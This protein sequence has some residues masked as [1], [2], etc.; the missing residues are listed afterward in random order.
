MTEPMTPTVPPIQPPYVEQSIS[1]QPPKQKR[2]KPR[3]S[4]DDIMANAFL[5]TA[6]KPV[7]KAMTMAY[8]LDIAGVM[9]LVG[10]ACVLVWLFDGW[11]GSFVQG[12]PLP[13]GVV[14]SGLLF[15]LGLLFL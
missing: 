14:G 11:F 1:P 13:D 15:N 3:R 10:Q 4:Q 7:K 12:V 2:K 5:K 8:F 9:V 6:F